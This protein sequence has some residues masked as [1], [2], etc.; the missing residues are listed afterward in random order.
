MTVYFIL[1]LNNAITAGV[2]LFSCLVCKQI[3][4]LTTCRGSYLTFQAKNFIKNFIE[5]GFPYSAALSN[6]NK[7]ECS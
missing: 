2:I 4:S 1:A 3:I 5:K 7:S 6:D